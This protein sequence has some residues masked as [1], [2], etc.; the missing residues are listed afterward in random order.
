MNIKER[1]A[2]RVREYPSDEVELMVE[3]KRKRK[4]LDEA[5]SLAAY[6]TMVREGR[7]K[8]PKKYWYPP[9]KTTGKI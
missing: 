9:R 2:A 5:V 6:E 7:D 4:A 3:G 1:L 8:L